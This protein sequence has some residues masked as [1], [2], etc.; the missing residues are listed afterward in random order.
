MRSPVG[1]DT[2]VIVQARLG[3]R[4][5]PGKINMEVTPGVTM[6][7]MVVHKARQLGPPV[8]VATPPPDMD[9]NDVLGR[10]W[11][12]AQ[13]HPEVKTFVRVTADCPLLDVGVGQRMLEQ[14]SRTRD[15]STPKW[16]STI[17]LFL[18]TTPD[19]DGLDVE[20]FCRHFLELAEH[21][22]GRGGEFNSIP[23]DREHVTTWMRR[24][25][26]AQFVTLGGLRTQWSVNE[27]TDLDWVR[28]VL[29]SCQ[30]CRSGIAH[31]SNAR[32]SIAGEDGRYPVWDLHQDDTG[33][34]VE[35][36]SY[37]IRKERMQ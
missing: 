1:D 37:D 18:G 5:L 15:L 7:Q 36:T 16:V 19:L 8:F 25:G 29:A 10:F 30:W 24:Q 13:L 33:G 17:P 32:G 11:R 12:V 28:R 2:L 20:I 21:H 3:S 27:Q 26:G 9:E 31:H 4:R 22:V 34:L 14:W 23:P 6:L 35:C